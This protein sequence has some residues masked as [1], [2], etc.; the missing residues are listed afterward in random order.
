MISAKPSAGSCL[1]GTPTVPIDVGLQ[2]R[3][4]RAAVH[5]SAKNVPEPALQRG[6]TKQVH[7]RGRIELDGKVDVAGRRCVTACDGTEQGEMADASAANLA[8]MSPEG[9]DDAP[10]LIRCGYCTLG[11]LR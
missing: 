4:A 3:P 10:G 8:L 5:A 1:E 7:A 9:S 6:Q 11:A 2:P